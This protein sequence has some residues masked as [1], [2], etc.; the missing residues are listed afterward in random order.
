[1]ANENLTD[2]QK[3]VQSIAR[4]L[5]SGDYDFDAENREYEEPCAAD[6]LGDV[7]DIE[8]IISSRK[9]YLGARLLVAFGGPNIWINTRSKQVEGYWWG[10][11]HFQSFEDTLGIDDYLEEIWGCM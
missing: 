3:N 7:L 5:T 10:E 1:M 8:Y 6:Y 11:S 9:D 2:L 4:Q